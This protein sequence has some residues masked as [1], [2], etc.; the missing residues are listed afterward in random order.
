MSCSWF[1]ERLDGLLAGSLPS[2]ERARAVAHAAECPRCGEVYELLAGVSGGGPAEAPGDLADAVLSRTSGRPCERARASLGDLLDGALG[3]VDR[4][5]VEA[6]L[7][8]CADCAALAAAAARLGVEL[9]ALAELP[10][11]SDLVDAVLARTHGRT[12][13]RPAA[14][15]GYSFPRPTRS[16]RWRDAVRRLFAR[17]RIA[18]E[19]GYVAALLVWLVFGAS[20]SPLRTTAV[21]ARVLL[22]QGVSVA[23][24]ASVG[25]VASVNRAIAT[26]SERTVRAARGASDAAERFALPWYRRVAAVAPDL[27]RHWRQLVQALED[28]DL[29]GGVAALRSLTRDAGAMLA[30]LLSP[31]SST[32]AADDVSRPAERSRP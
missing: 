21:E 10:P 20:W 13:S 1:D 28:R 9:P 30:E 15:G 11:P 7:G 26:V 17:P 25:S 14:A 32:P 5:L 29:F 3:P 27:G 4:R 22:E 31:S 19:A 2:A 18:W 16:R 8:H 24:D 12:A 6:H 23:R